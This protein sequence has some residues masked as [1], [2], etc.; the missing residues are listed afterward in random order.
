MA[1]DKAKFLNS[2][3]NY[4][5]SRIVC[6]V[7]FQL[8]NLTIMKRDIFWDVAACSLIDIYRRSR[9]ASCFQDRLDDGDSKLF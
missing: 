2:R 1:K 5:A 8:P 7:I 4:C 6:L 9:G 3:T